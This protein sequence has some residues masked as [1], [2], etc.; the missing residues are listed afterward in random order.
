MPSRILH[1]FSPRIDIVRAPFDFHSYGVYGYISYVARAMPPRNSV[2]SQSAPQRTAASQTGFSYYS[3]EVRSINGWVHR[4]ALA[5]ARLVSDRHLPGP[6]R[7]IGLNRCPVQAPK[8]CLKCSKSLTVQTVRLVKISFAFPTV[9][10][11]R[12]SNTK[13]KSE[14]M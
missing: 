10:P 4:S 9:I 8:N 12:T 3:C 6:N 5:G 11:R 1:Y 7:F 13:S 2:K 14:G